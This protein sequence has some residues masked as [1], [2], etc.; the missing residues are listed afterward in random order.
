MCSAVVRK[1]WIAQL[2]WRRLTLFSFSFNLWLNEASYGG[3][4]LL[5]RRVAILLS[6]FIFIEYIT[7]FRKHIASNAMNIMNSISILYTEWVATN[8]HLRWNNK[9]KRT[10]YSNKYPLNLDNKQR[11]NFVK[12]PTWFCKHAGVCTSLFSFRITYW[13]RSL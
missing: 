8:S 12:R 3:R 6:Q 1:A 11:Q 4:C 5:W 7:R 10:S 9:H 2:W 13:S